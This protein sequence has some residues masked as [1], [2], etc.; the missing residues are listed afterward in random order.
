MTVPG[1]YICVCFYCSRSY[2]RKEDRSWGML[3]TQ[4]G[5]ANK[6]RV[7]NFF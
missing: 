4:P 2:A 6:K 5:K 3:K 1:L 7:G